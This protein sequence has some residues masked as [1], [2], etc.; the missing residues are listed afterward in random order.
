[1]NWARALASSVLPTPVGPA[2][3]NEPAGQ[4]NARHL[5]DDLGHHLVV[6]DPVG[7]AAL[8]PPVAGHRLLLLLQLVGL[9]AERR[10]LFEVLVGDR[11]LLL[12]VE[13]FDL[14]VDLLEVWRLRHR[15]EPHAGPRLV[16]D[17]DRLVRE[18]AAGDVAAGKLHRA[19]QGRVA[20]RHAVVALVAVAEALED[21]HRL[22]L[23][24]RLHHDDLEPPVER[25]ILLDVL[26]VLVE[27]GGADALD[28]APG[29]GRLEHVGGVDRPLGAA[30]AHE[31]VQFVDEQDRVLCA[32][33]LVHHRLDPLLELAAVLRARDHH[34]EVEDDD[35]AVGEQLGHVAIDHPLGEAFHDRRLAHAR[36]AEEDRIVLRAAA[37]DLDRPLDLLL[38]ADDRIEL[39]LAGQLGEVPAEAVEGRRLALAGLGAA[40]ATTTAGAGRLPAAHPGPLATLLHAVAEEVEHL[41]SDVL[42]LEAEVHQDLGRHAFL[43]P[44]QAE[45][46]VLGADVVV[47][48]VPG[49]LHRILDHLL[50]PGRLRELAHRDHVGPALDELLD[51][52][53]DLPQVDVEILEDVGRDAAA[54]LDQAEEHVLGADV[55]V[56][57]TLGLL[58]GQLHHLPRPVRETLVHRGLPSW[59]CPGGRGG[60]GWPACHSGRLRSANERRCKPH[61]KPTAGL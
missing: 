13:P 34:G 16:D 41:L 44:E 52:H 50:G 21:L 31:R 26:A 2:N 22:V 20:D 33:D 38:T 28:L 57:E 46:D 3:T 60:C 56:V 48:E 51:F 39:A 36:L 54:L 49:L 23:R 42:E 55:L 18:A 37:K 6:H 17:V 10:R 8:V 40:L 7:L 47:V 14:L 9:V 1:M 35:A 27:R 45:Q 19:L 11:L 30:G 24:G 58:I 15:L 29:E 5:G 4:R 12:L 32:A 43:L 25:R 59:N 61:A 53:A